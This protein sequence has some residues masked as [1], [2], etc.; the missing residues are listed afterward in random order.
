MSH[1]KVHLRHFNRFTVLTYQKVLKRPQT[2]RA[3]KIKASQR[4]KFQEKNKSVKL[5][6]NR[7][8]D[9]LKHYLCGGNNAK[10]FKYIYYE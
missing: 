7:L 10:Q 4:R 2:K 5:L 1:F 8:K 6:L 9:Y 3:N